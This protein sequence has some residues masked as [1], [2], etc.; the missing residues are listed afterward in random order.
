MTNSPQIVKE[1]EHFASLVP[2]MIKIGSE[3]LDREM[4]R[5]ITG[6]DRLYSNSKQLTREQVSESIKMS[7]KKV[8]A[9]HKQARD[10]I[11]TKKSQLK[12][13]VMPAVQA[14]QKAVSEIL[15]SRYEALG[16]Q[17]SF[18]LRVLWLTCRCLSLT[19]L[20]PRSGARTRPSGRVSLEFCTEN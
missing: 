18:D 4:N 2:E 9:Q 5:M 14:Q 19:T 16:K 7:D 12:N 17:V 6:L 1:G 3:A 15:G 8:G 13:K 11:A 20:L 10:G